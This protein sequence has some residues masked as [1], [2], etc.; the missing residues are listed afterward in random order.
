M[1]SEAAELPARQHEAEVL[2][3]QKHG[4]QFTIERAVALL[5]C[6]QLR[7]EESKRPTVAATAAAHRNVCTGGV[8]RQ[9][10]LCSIRRVLQ[11]AEVAEG[12]LGGRE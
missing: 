11:A 8:R 1:V 9:G 3:R 7:G 4:Q 10:E 6:F 2:Q 5:G 12:S